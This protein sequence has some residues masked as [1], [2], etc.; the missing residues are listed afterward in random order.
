MAKALGSIITLAAAIVVNVVPGL[1]QLA[2]AAILV[3]AALVS[4]GLN[5]LLAGS[6]KPETTKRT[7]KEPIPPRVYAYGRSRLYGASV[8]YETASDGATVDVY[9]FCQGPATAIETYYLND[10][11]ITLSAPPFGNV[12]VALA[13]GSYGDGKVKTFVRLGPTPGEAHGPVVTKL[14]DIWTSNHRGDG[15]VSGYLIKDPVK[16]ADF[17]KIYPQGD[18]VDLSVVGQWR[19]CFDPRTDTTA[20]TQN[21]VLQFMDYLVNVRGVDYT[22][23]ILPRISLWNT[24]AN[25]CEEQIAL[26]EGGTENRYN[27]DVSFTSLTEPKAVIAAFLETFDGFL[28]RM[29]D[30]SY[31]IYAGKGYTPTVSIGADEIVGYAFQDGIDDENAVSQLVVSYI[32]AAHDYQTV[33][34]T[35]W[36]DVGGV[37]RAEQF[38]PQTSS[39]SQNRRLAKRLFAKRNPTL[40]GSVQCNLGARVARGQRFINLT[41]E[42]GGMTFFDGVVEITGYTRSFADGIISIDWIAYDGNVDSWNPA[43]EQGDPAPLGERVEREPL[44]APTITSAV[45]IFED[46][47][48]GAVGARIEV[49]VPSTGRADEQWYLRWRVAGAS[50]WNEQEYADTDPGADVILT[51]GFVPS[52]P[53]LEVEVAYGVGDGRFS[54]FSATVDVD[55]TIAGSTGNLNFDQIAQSGLTVLFSEDF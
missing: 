16:S 41:I 27:S 5:S 10:Q 24:A 29:G 40:S 30:G 9:A 8:L 18:N 46:A 26:R 1:G 6:Q 12:V 32:S 20:W 33:E 54:P 25:I 19:S 52:V 49:T 17:L 13:D 3:G 36:G 48:E 15:V 42:E 34:C 22:A 44:D 39:Y 2:S 47:T 28:A 38:S 14:P 45:A 50:A 11:L 31:V 37:R 7:I 43:T 53:V 55:S 23:Q 4:A 35:P 21:P 51:S